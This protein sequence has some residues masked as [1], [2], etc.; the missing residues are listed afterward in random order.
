MY[1]YISIVL[2]QL[3]KSRKRREKKMLFL[4]REKEDKLKEENHKI[5]Q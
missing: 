2:K 3:L 4:K 5:L 1:I